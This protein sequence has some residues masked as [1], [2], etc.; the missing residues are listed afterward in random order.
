MVKVTQSIASEAEALARE[1][2]M[3]QAIYRTRD[4]I[5]GPRAFAEKRPPKFEG[6]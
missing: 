5:E 3:G 4:A 6:R 2:E 1:A